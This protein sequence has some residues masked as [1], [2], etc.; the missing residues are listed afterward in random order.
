VPE[1]RRAA[2]LALLA[3]LT[4]F[5]VFRPAL[6][7]PVLAWDDAVNVG[8]SAPLALTAQGVDAM[9]FGSSLG[10]WAPV[11]R[12][13]LAVDRTLWNG[14][15]FGYHLGSVLWQALCAALFFLLARRLL[16]PAATR[17]LDADL[18]ALFAALA[19]AVH[20]LR[21]ESVAWITER[22]DVVSGAFILASAL[23]WV[24]GAEAGEN[25][26]GARLR[27]AA[28]ALG[29]LA[30]AAK[31]F[32][33]T[34]PAAL[35]ILDARLRGRPRWREKL[36]W[37][38]PAGLSVVFNS[39]A[40]A[41]SGAAV[42]LSAFDARARLLQA[43]YGLAFYARKSA[44]PAHLSPLYETSA[45]L[46]PLPF[47]LSA[48]AVV[49]A[50]ALLWRRRRA[51]PGLAQAALAYALLA[52]PA[53]G[54]FKSGRMTA[55]DRYSYLPSLPL[56]LLAGAAFAR[57]ASRPAARAAALAVIFGFAAVAR[58]QLPVW[59]SDAALWT[60]ACAEEPLSY[61]ARLRLADAL[62]A[63]GRPE[64]ADAAVSAAQDLHRRVFE[65]A[66]EL[67]DARG[68]AAEA[69]ADRRRAA[70][71]IDPALLS[72]TATGK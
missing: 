52:L 47:W 61:F 9:I 39:I 70:A 27:R 59:S 38:V 45:R 67:A 23:C 69:D 63:E 19:W 15:A 62:R 10:H 7:Y 55:A 49:A 46:E 4:T 2:L 68:A 71:G 72:P 12:L 24:H 29:A 56:A 28:L 54:L 44:W 42:P 13:T 37:L 11:T 66:A 57:A 58:A 36:P 60:R 64:A 16:R 65:R 33:A 25:A 17:P 18:G 8:E 5:A 32:A 14:S 1:R 30:M 35:L 40:Q 43:A 6:R 3:A 53:L 31:V 21:V 22:R 51:A 20:P 50:A 26:R 41:N 48:A 34:L